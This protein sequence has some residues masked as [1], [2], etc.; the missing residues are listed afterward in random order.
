MM[1]KK[2]NLVFD[3][4]YFS[5][6]PLFK[7]S[8][9]G[10]KAFISLKE[11]GDMFSGNTENRKKYFRKLKVD[12]ERVSGIRQVH[13]KDIRIVKDTRLG[14]YIKGD[15][16]ITEN[17]NAV[18]SVSVADCIPVCIYDS[19]LDI[20]GVLHS[21]WRGTGIAGKAVE[22]L[23]KNYNSNP[24][25]I[26]M[27]IGPGI[28]GCCYEVSEELYMSFG[29]EYGGD[30]VNIKRNKYYVDLIE[31]NLSLLKRYNIKNITVI[32]DCT[33]CSK[34]LSSYRRDGAE[35]FCRM[36]VCIGNI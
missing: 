35:N 30:A 28:R 5:E 17:R 19:A 34:L 3:N 13:S 7:K 25:N 14:P 15:G 8:G 22:F 6:L 29:N 31:A 16:L 24:E 10:I 12:Y 9:S 11:S 27:T 2:A 21:G 26:F 18:L 32:E 33:F 23:I 1:I 4:P 36:T 20:F